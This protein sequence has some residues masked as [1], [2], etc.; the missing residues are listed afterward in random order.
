MEKG[1][2]MDRQCTATSKQSKKR[3]LR[4][5]IPGGTVCVMHGGA[6]PHVQRSAAE[7]LRA[8]VDPAITVIEDRPLDSNEPG[9]QARVAADILDRTGYSGKQKLEVTGLDDGPVKFDLSGFSD[10]DLATFT[11][12]LGRASGRSGG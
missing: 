2:R 5:A 8:L 3:C 10:D 12:L 1:K 6:A 9:L 4:S 7:R 11:K